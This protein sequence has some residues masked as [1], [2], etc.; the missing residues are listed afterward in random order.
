[1]DIQTDADGTIY[2][3]NLLVSLGWEYVHFLFLNK[4]YFSALNKLISL[5][6]FYFLSHLPFCM[7]LAFIPF[8]GCPVELIGKIKKPINKKW[9]K[10]VE[11]NNPE[12]IIIISRQEKNIL[13]LFIKNSPELK[14]YNNIEILANAADVK[15]GQFTGKFRISIRQYHKQGYINDDLVYLGDLRDY[16]LWGRK[17]KKFILI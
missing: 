15:D 9:L 7:K 13:Q 12:K 10:I 8:R 3:G 17:K 2:R 4:K 11:K 1:M 5:I 6:F 16:V 14:K